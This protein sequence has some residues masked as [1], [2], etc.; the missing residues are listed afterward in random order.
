MGHRCSGSTQGDRGEPG[1]G[2]E[3]GTP[4]PKVVSSSLLQD[5]FPLKCILA[6]HPDV[7]QVTKSQVN[8]WQ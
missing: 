2:G 6:Q 8:I 1:T 7:K 4:G 3:P 5:Y